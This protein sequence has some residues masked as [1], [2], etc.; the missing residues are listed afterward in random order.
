MPGI[1]EPGKSPYRLRYRG[2]NVIRIN[3]ISSVTKIKAFYE[4]LRNKSAIACLINYY[5]LGKYVQ[6]ITYTVV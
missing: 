6:Y 5:L 2:D 1:S 3:T 4:I